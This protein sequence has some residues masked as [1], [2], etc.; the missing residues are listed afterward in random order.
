MYRLW[1]TEKNKEKI[2]KIETNKQTDRETE[3]LKL[4][5]GKSKDCNIKYF[6]PFKIL[7]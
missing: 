6:S 5:Y 4:N 7:L 2:N 3:V 1:E